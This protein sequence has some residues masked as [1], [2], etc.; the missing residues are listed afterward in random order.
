MLAGEGVV[1][2]LVPPELERDDPPVLDDEL[3]VERDGV[4]LDG[5]VTVVV[6]VVV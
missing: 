2:V 5:T 6:V 4:V 3:F 1:V